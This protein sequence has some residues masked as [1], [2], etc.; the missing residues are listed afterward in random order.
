MIRLAGEPVAE[1]AD[2]RLQLSG[3][4]P[5]R[6]VGGKQ[7]LR[8]GCSI[9]PQL[10][11]VDCRQPSVIEHH[12]A[13]DHDAVDGATV[14]GKDNLADDIVARHI[15]DVAEVEKD[16][17]GFV[18]WRDVAD[19]PAKPMAWALPAVAMRS[20]SSAPS[21]DSKSGACTREISAASRADSNI[22]S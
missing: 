17:V 4:C 13:A 3:K 18:A 9:L 8:R 1:L 10:L 22:L 19:Q 11:F 12:A 6:R 2:D 7:T 15:I 16:D 21:Q 5:R 20:T 14:F